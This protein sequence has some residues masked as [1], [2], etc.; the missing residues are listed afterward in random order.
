MAGYRWRFPVVPATVAHGDPGQSHPPPEVSP[1]AIPGIG[2][3]T[4]SR[5]AAAPAWDHPAKNHAEE[6]V[7]Q[8]RR[9]ARRKLSKLP[10]S[11]GVYASAPDRRQMEA[12]SGP[13]LEPFAIPT[14]PPHTLAP[15]SSARCRRMF[16]PADAPGHDPPRR[17]RTGRQY[18]Q[19]HVINASVSPKGSL[20]TLSQREVQQLSEVG[21]GSLY[22]LFRQC[23]LA[24]LNTGAHVDNA[25]TILDAYRTSRCA[26][27]NRTVACAWNC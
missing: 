17:H 18:A 5:T 12:G 11:A 24:I 25:K 13:S 15:Q 3:R 26:S 9:L 1:G 10:V 16:H 4:D 21:T 7:S 23:A 19:R 14:H 22:T 6:K 8:S 20:E 27:T 2:K